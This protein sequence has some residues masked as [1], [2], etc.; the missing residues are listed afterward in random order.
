MKIIDNPEGIHP[1]LF[2]E[3]FHNHHHYQPHDG[4]SYQE[5]WDMEQPQ[6][7][8]DGGQPLQAQ[9][10]A[11]RMMPAMPVQPAGAAPAHAMAH[12][13]AHGLVPDQMRHAA[14]LQ[15]LQRQLPG[16]P[17]VQPSNP[18]QSLIQDTTLPQHFKTLLSAMQAEKAGE[19]Q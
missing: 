16:Q 11:Q 1:D 8:A 12:S 5:P 13:P 9:F 17:A 2:M 14:L 19:Q 6:G 15:A 3:Q 4:S 18:I 10:N 7:L